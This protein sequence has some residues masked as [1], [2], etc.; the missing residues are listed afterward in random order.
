MTSR[1]ASEFWPMRTGVGRSIREDGF[2][3]RA[4]ED[5]DRMFERERPGFRPGMGGVGR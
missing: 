2:G 3:K 1:M 4:M 5:G